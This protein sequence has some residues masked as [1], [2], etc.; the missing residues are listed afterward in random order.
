[1]PNIA[2]YTATGELTPS[3]KGIQ[4]AEAAGRRLGQ[5]GHELEG[6]VKEVTNAYEQ[7]QSLVEVS[8][9]SR[10]IS[11]ANIGI[12]NL[13]DQTLADPANKGRPDLAQNMLS[14]QIE[15]FVQQLAG[16]AKTEAGKRYAI[17]QGSELRTRW[18]RE[19][20]ADQADVIATQV[21]ENAKVQSNNASVA[22]ARAPDQASVDSNVKDLNTTTDALSQQMV[23]GGVPPAKVAEW[24]AQH[25][26]NGLH[27]IAVARA[28]SLIEKAALEIGQT[29]DPTKS[30][31]YAAAKDIFAT[32]PLMRDHLTGEQIAELNTRLE[33]AV[34]RGH[35]LYNSA[36]A[37][38]HRKED[39]AVN[40]ALLSLDGQ[41][42]VDNGAGGV[43]TNV[44]PEMLKSLNQISQMPGAPRH[45]AEINAFRH[46]LTVGTNETISG[47]N[48]VTD[49]GV[50]A[51]LS[52]RIGSTAN[53]LTKAEVDEQRDHLSAADWRFLRE[54]AA[55]SK[56]QHPKIASAISEL[57]RA[58]DQQ[59][60]TIEQIDPITHLPTASG[61]E[62]FAAWSWEGEDFVRRQIAAGV[63]PDKAIHD[64]TDPHNKNGMYSRI[65]AY[66]AAAEK[67]VQIGA[68]PSV[69]GKPPAAMKDE[70]TEAY[71]TRTK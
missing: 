57:H 4:A 45:L 31:I 19:L 52:G 35:E 51:G 11:D 38:Q 16:M 42:T 61:A 60:A 27:D 2:E 65:P 62:Q 25:L 34:T 67:G 33:G 3:D 12:G 43:T 54:S 5:Y 37:T 29:D 17:E 23:T 48:R 18:A 9:M 24:K 21:D 47:E 44:S 20:H 7:H 36:L 39:D 15:P 28:M 63:D 56:S 49:R 26:N 50:Y 6:D 66:K 70:G 58:Q 71:L 69:G 53:P 8:H 64:Y 13:W 68:V 46:A 30:P 1:M 22:V 40:G 14:T 32:D 41:M 55:D 59:R 10:A